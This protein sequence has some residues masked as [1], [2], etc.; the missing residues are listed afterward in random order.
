MSLYTF[1]AGNAMAS[2]LKTLIYLAGGK[3]PQN[4][5]PISSVMTLALPWG[6]ARW[7]GENR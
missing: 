4:V 2:L 1:V 3:V 6:A 7:S 5:M